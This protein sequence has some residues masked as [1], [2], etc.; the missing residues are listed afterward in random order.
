MNH[1]IVIIQTWEFH[2]ECLFYIFRPTC[3]HP[4]NM[5]AIRQH[6]SKMCSGK[7]D[8]RGFSYCPNP[9]NYKIEL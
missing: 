9:F 7:Y 2:N 3:A 4:V 1:N 8:E 5:Q 6:V